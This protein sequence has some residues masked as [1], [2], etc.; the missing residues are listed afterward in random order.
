M[1]DAKSGRVNSGCQEVQKVEKIRFER[2][3]AC[4][5]SASHFGYGIRHSQRGV[6]PSAHP[7]LMCVSPVVQ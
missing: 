1:L 2:A 6:G 5:I 4:E 7:V 3:E